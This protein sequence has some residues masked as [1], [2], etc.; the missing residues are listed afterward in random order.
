MNYLK[1]VHNTVLNIQIV[2][3]M[4]AWPI[5][6]LEC[7]AER[8]LQCKYNSPIITWEEVCICMKTGG[9]WL[10][11]RSSGDCIGW[12]SASSPVKVGSGGWCVLTSHWYRPESSVLILDTWSLIRPSPRA[13]LSH[14]TRPANCP[15]WDSGDSTP[16][17][18]WYRIK[19][20]TSVN[21]WQKMLSEVEEL[22]GLVVNIHSSVM[23]SF[24][25]A[26]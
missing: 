8:V 6:V 2:H 5:L 1:A 26:W 23:L 4:D 9:G 24:S 22:S 15:S 19:D 20:L 10:Q 3:S 14:W 12:L 17:C 13:S 16:S 25:S 18:T 11:D 21:S 7:Y